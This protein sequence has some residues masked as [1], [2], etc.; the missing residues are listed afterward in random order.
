MMLDSSELGLTV[1]ITGSG[2]W[3]GAGAAC[4]S[5]LEGTAL[6]ETGARTDEGPTFSFVTFNYSQSYIKSTTMG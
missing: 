6:T 3:V 2:A 5:G 1:E 4:L